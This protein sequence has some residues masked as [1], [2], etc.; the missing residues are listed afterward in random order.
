MVINKRLVRKLNAG[1]VDEFNHSRW[2]VE[3]ELMRIR[4]FRKR[5]EGSRVVIAMLKK[6]NPDQ[7]KFDRG[8]V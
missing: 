8:F 7:N 3:I 2:E 1:Q 6:Q 5:E 4:K